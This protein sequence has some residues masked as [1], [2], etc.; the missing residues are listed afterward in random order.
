MRCRGAEELF[1]GGSGIPEGGRLKKLFSSGW[2]IAGGGGNAI[3]E[4]IS[5]QK[6]ML[7]IHFLS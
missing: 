5:C 6:Q 7:E 2:V 4:D 1:I 3:V